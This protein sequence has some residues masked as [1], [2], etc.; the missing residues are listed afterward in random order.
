[1]PFEANHSVVTMPTVS[2]PPWR[3]PMTSRTA[4]ASVSATSS[5][6]KS[7]I[8]AMN[9]SAVSRSPRKPASAARKVTNGNSEKNAVNAM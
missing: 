9:S 6:M 1:M 7:N 3:A 8:A 4:G 2:S 5:G